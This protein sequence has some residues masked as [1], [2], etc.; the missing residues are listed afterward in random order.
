MD[1]LELAD[2]LESDRKKMAGLPDE[3]DRDMD[4]AGADMAARMLIE[5][6]DWYRTAQD[7]RE[8]PRDP[9]N[10]AG[11]LPFVA[12][13]TFK[14][15][16]GA[17]NAIE[18]GGKALHVAEDVVDEMAPVKEA[19]ASVKALSE[20]P[21]YGGSEKQFY[22]ALSLGATKAE[23]NGCKN[24]KDTSALIT[25]LEAG[26][27]G[28]NSSRRV[29]EISEKQINA[30]RRGGYTA[31][32]ISDMT[33]K[34]ADRIIGEMFDEAKAANPDIPDWDGSGTD[35]DKRFQE[36]F[37]LWRNNEI[38]NVTFEKM[39]GKKPEIPT[40]SEAVATKRPAPA[41]NRVS[42][43][44]L[45]SVP[46]DKAEV[47]ERVS[48]KP[49]VAEVAP[50][51]LSLPVKDVP[52]SAPLSVGK[53][54]GKKAFGPA[55]SGYIRQVDEI[56]TEFP[57]LGNRATEYAKAG[58]NPK[59]LADRLM[60]E[61]EV[62]KAHN[63]EQAA[64]IKARTTVHDGVHVFEEGNLPQLF[65]QPMEN[66]RH[67]VDPEVMP[68]LKRGSGF[69]DFTMR[70]PELAVDAESVVEAPAKL[71]LPAAAEIPKGSK[72]AKALA[73]SVLV[74]TGGYMVGN[75]L[76]DAYPIPDDVQPDD[77]RIPVDAAQ[78]QRD[79]GKTE[80]RMWSPEE[81]DRLFNSPEYKAN[82]KAGKSVYR[83]P[84]WGER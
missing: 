60:K 67:V 1:Y 70:H 48:S 77:G 35:A 56:V 24:I 75:R 46:A 25:K 21:Q 37:E 66:A 9:W 4:L 10:Y 81:F 12:G 3:Y 17:K 44:R 59:A 32:Q 47:L 65:E 34:E 82:R 57:E 7:I 42:T 58:M 14:A 79:D 43:P 45:E 40:P 64:A 71:A 54:S 38:D 19:I 72:A 80:K 11:F 74:G 73:A 83:T 61:A 62:L 23:L 84:S 55:A 16:K 18:G 31:Q 39:T 52:Q 76:S 41:E 69:T 5:P 26:G 50:P 68:I 15:V 33:P 27:A 28:V 8:N 51:E 22:K 49:S 20:V 63:L 78:M 6:Y 53:V 30:L 36:A 2:R 13:G 29:R